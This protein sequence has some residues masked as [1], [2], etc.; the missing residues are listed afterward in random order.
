MVAVYND[1]CN[2]GGRDNSLSVLMDCLANV[3]YSGLKNQVMRVRYLH[4]SV[5]PVRK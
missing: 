4:L 5:M 2:N 3:E 1:Y